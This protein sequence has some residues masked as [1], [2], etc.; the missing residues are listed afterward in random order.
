MRSRLFALS[1][2]LALVA[3]ATVAALAQ[4]TKT[5]ESAAPAPHPNGKRGGVLQA[6]HREDLAQGFSIHETATISTSWPVMPCFNNLV[7]DPDANFYENF[8]CDS[9]RNYM[10]YCDEQVMKLIDA[11]SQELD[12]PKRAA[13][14]AQI[15]RKLEEQLRTHAGGLAGAVG[16]GNAGRAPR[17]P[18]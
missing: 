1:I 15:Q 11:Q 2:G 8:A 14:V 7:D 5:Q 6:M 13:L 10:G 17:P 3:L 9:P 18:S 16:A 12:V 4:G